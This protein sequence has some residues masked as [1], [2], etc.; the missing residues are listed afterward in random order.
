MNSG[1]WK[2]SSVH[3]QVNEKQ[4][5][6]REAARKEGSEVAKSMIRWKIV[7]DLTPQS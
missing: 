7:G 6:R 3:K 1:S 4:D 2:G 5:A